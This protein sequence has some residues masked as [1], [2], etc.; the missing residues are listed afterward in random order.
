MRFTTIVTSKGQ[1]TIPQPVRDKLEL[2]RGTKVDIYP[3][4]NGF[5]GRLHRKSKITAFFGDLSNLDQNEPLEEIR[6]KTQQIA[7]E[8]LVNKSSQDK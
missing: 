5:I 2:E 3:T 1:L 8:E 7:S 6:K 4:E